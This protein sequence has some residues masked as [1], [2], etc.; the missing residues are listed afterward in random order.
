MKFFTIAL[1]LIFQLSSPVASI[2]VIHAS[3]RIKS[4]ALI[5]LIKYTEYCQCYRCNINSGNP[6]E[7]SCDDTNTGALI[8][9]DEGFSGCKIE[10]EYDGMQRSG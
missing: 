9:C 2:K 3:I 4:S 8:E 1:A 10:S 7:K 6:E 5:S